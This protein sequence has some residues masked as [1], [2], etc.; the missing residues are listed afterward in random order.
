MTADRRKVVAAGPDPLSG[1]AHLHRVPHDPLAADRL[2]AGLIGRLQPAE[3]RRTEDHAE[4]EG[5][6]G[7]VALKHRD[8]T[9]R[10][11]RLQ[12]DRGIQPTWSSAYDRDL[13]VMSDPP[14]TRRALTVNISKLCPP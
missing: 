14:E 9:R 13:H 12:Q 11:R 2:E 5:V 1:V 6:I 10:I 4:A 7:G 3:G 8:V